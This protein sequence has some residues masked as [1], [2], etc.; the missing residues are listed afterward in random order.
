MEIK[1]SFHQAWRSFWVLKKVRTEPL[2]ARLAISTGLA[3]AI[4]F[5]IVVLSGIFGGRLDDF[6]WWRSLLATNALI[7]FSICYVIHA[8]YRGLELLLP[9]TVIN[10]LS[11]IRDW[12]IGLFFSAVS[13]TGAVLGGAI[14]FSLIGAVFK[15]DVWGTLVKDSQGLVTFLGITLVITAANWLWWRQRDKQNALQRLATEA[16]L[17]MLQAQIEPHFLFNTLANVQSLMVYEPQRASQMLEAFTDYLRGSLGQ[18]RKDDSTLDAELEMAQSYL[19]LL[20]I[21]MGDRLSFV[22]DAS[23]EARLAMLPPLLLQPLIENAIHHGLEPKIEGGQI[24][25]SAKVNSGRLEVFIED[26]GLGLDQPRRPAR[27]G[28]GMALENIRTRLQTRYSDDASLTLTGQ[29]EGVRASLNLPYTAR[30]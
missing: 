22:I 9:D 3:I 24:R 28:G 8:L 1:N 6:R 4:T 27:P 19:Q 7:C 2:W 21:R 18:L 10:R 23:P 16:Q 14:G 11:A 17:R 12:R 30:S 20:Q 5:G 26:D 15:V 13:I 25:V 29:P